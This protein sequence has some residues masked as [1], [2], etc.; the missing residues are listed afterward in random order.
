MRKTASGS[1]LRSSRELLDA[2]KAA[3]ALW[4]AGIGNNMD[5]SGVD[6]SDFDDDDDAAVLGPFILEAIYTDSTQQSDFEARIAGV[7]AA[8]HGKVEGVSLFEEAATMFEDDRLCVTASFSCRSDIEQAR[9]DAHRLER[10]DELLPAWAG[11]PRRPR[12]L[13]RR[14]GRRL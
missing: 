8:D 3:E 9:R 11:R 4:A 14:L 6:E 7:I 13:E 10:R 1:S 2:E 5:E 12:R